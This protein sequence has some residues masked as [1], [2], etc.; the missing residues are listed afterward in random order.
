MGMA[1]ERYLFVFLAVFILTAILVRGSHADRPASGTSLPGDPFAGQEWQMPESGELPGDPFADEPAFQKAIEGAVKRQWDHPLD[2]GSRFD[3]HGYLESRNRLRTGSDNKFLSARQRLWLEAD[4]R[5]SPQM[6]FFASGALDIDPAAADL[7]DDHETVRA[8]LNEAY[9]TFDRDTLDLILGR[10]MLRWGMGDGINPLDLINPLDH[11]DPVASGRADSRVPVNLVQTLVRLPA[12]G[13]LQEASLEGVVIPQARVNTLNA[14][15]SPWENQGLKA[16]RQAQSR[17]D[18][19]LNGQQEPD[20]FFQDAEFGMRLAVTFSGW[21]LALIGFS[22][23]TDT[24]VFS[25][26]PGENG[27][28]QL[29]PV[30]P[31]FSAFGINFAKGLDRSTLRGELALKPDL[32]VMLTDPA[33]IPGYERRPVV[34]GVLGVDRTFGTNLYTNLQYFG[35]FI[36]DDRDLARDRYDHGITYEINDLFWQDDLKAGIR[37]MISF[38][39]QS[40]TCEPYAEFSL[41]DDWLLA[42]SLLVFEGSKESRSGQFTDNDMLTVRLRYSF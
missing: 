23:F 26:S 37:G 24:P 13:L 15:G 11:R 35:T 33:A 36:E 28:P 29:T 2:K 20:D 25:R 31:A 6:R 14:P 27:V 17:G 32:P 9:V 7:S 21:D 10:K 8:H 3:L 22:G 42:T 40:W 19:I 41:G 34:E 4:G 38:S 39:D 1:A 18:L 12:F 5:F 30:H 16:L